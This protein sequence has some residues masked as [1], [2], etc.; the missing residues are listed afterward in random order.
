[1][2]YRIHS[3]VLDQLFSLRA[4]PLGVLSCIPGENGCMEVSYEKRG[5]SV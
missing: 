2:V 3:W 1:M 5:E 4:P